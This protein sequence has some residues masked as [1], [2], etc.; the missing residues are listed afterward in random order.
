VCEGIQCL[1]IA[2]MLFQAAD[3]HAHI[4]KGIVDMLAFG[5]VKGHGSGGG[6]GVRR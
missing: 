2:C 6:G 1:C 3:T 4:T 5:G